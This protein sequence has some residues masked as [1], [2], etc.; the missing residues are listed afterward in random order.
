MT[1][2]ARKALP[3]GAMTLPDGTLLIVGP[4]PDIPQWQRDGLA[5]LGSSAASSTRDLRRRAARELRR[6]RKRESKA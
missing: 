1:A 5:R 6:Q 4:S 3:T 2:D